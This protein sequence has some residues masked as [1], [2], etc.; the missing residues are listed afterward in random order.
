M[1][2]WL[3]RLRARLHA[4]SADRELAALWRAKYEALRAQMQERARRDRDERDALKA[5][6]MRR[7]R[8]INSVETLQ[9]MLR[10]RTGLAQRRAQ[11]T[12]AN[13]GN[14]QPAAFDGDVRAS[15]IDGLTWWV[16]AFPRQSPASINR[17][18]L[19]QRFPYRGIA[20]TRDVAVGGIMLDIG[21]NV[22]RMAIPRVILGDSTKVF[23]AEPDNLNFQCLLANIRDNRLEGLV[24]PDRVAISDHIGSLPLKRG[25]MSGAHRVVYSGPPS[26]DAERVPCTT[27]DAWVQRHAIDLADVTFVKVDTQGSEVHVLAGASR[28]LAQDHIGWQIEVSPSDLQRAG[29]D[30]ETLYGILQEHFSHFID[31]NAEADGPRLRPISDIS[32][33]LAYLQRTND[34]HSDIIAYRVENGSRRS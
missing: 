20:Q 24:I 18:L 12:H 15:C 34:T 7:A 14:G 25:K 31:L 13:A 9:H 27:L 10:A 29:S 1:A 23:C 32:A 5:Q 8:R 2:G 17:M 28:V 3:A 22:G 19:K 16:P 30:V 26:D 21:A 6:S 11:Q 33:A 4:A